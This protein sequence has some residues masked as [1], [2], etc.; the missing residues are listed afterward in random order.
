MSRRDN[1]RIE[2]AGLDDVPNLAPLYDAYRQFYEQ[3]GDLP[4]AER[5]L[6]DRLARDESLVW[7]ARHDQQAVGF[8]QCYPTFCSVSA[9]SI[10]VLYDLYVMPAARGLGAARA[11]MQAAQN[12]AIAQ[13]CVRLELSTAKT[14]LVAQRLYQSLG[15]Q[16]DE[17]FWYFSLALEPAR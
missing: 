11:L 6:R 8:C 9:G 12:E 2:R 13:G 16:R 14:N 1:L 4:L 3:P 10:F 5:F 7:V 15:W 17:V